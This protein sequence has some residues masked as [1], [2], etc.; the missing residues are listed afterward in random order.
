VVTNVP[1]VLAIK[2]IVLEAIKVVAMGVAVAWA[3]S[4]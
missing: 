3:Y 2:Q 1:A 4:R